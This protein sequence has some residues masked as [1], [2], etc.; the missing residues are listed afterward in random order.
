M[1]SVRSWRLISTALAGLCCL[2]AAGTPAWAAFPGA[3]GKIAFVH[4][5]Q[6]WSVDPDG[7]NLGLLVDVGGGADEEPDWSADGQRIAF[8]HH[9]SATQIEV[10]VA[11]ADGSNAH[12]VV[13]NGRSPSWSPDG[14]RIAFE[15]V[16]GSFGYPDLF[17]VNADGTGVVQITSTNDWPET[18]PAWSPDG[19]K[20]AFFGINYVDPAGGN[21]T[22]VGG[23]QL[24]EWSPF[25]DEL[26]SL[27]RT[28]EDLQLRALDGTKHVTLMAS[29]VG[30]PAFSPDGTTIVFRRDGGLYRISYDGTGFG[31]MV[32]APC[33][34]NRGVAWQPIPQPP[35]PRYV[36]PKGATFTRVPLVPAYQACEAPDRQH[37]PPLAFGSCSAPTQTSTATTVG[38]PD[39]NGRP[40]ASVGFASYDVIAGDPDTPEDEADVRIKV[41]VDDVRRASDLSDYVWDFDLPLQF[42]LTY[43]GAGVDQATMREVIENTPP[44]YTS[45]LRATVPCA[46]TADAG[47]GSVCV[48]ETSADAILAGMVRESERA[49]WELRQVRLFDAGPDGYLSSRDDNE[50]FAVQGVFVP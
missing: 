3:N 34:C 20:I 18:H 6:L 24:P 42:R 15:R 48:V 47:T 17:L 10:W 2:A 22:P 49:I 45:Q 44:W 26:A 9:V 5:D 13:A 21:R 33:V 38:T 7:S 37:G 36:R 35:A 30:P 31:P 1:V 23:G 4:Q 27:T 32:S 8:E 14:T 39:A 12:L 40:A 43:R 28:R 19:T 50:L 41:R 16:V 29:P 46:A 11:D 25:G